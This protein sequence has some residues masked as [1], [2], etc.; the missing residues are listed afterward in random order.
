M[1]VA[2][3]FTVSCPL[4][5]ILL[6]ECDNLWI[7]VTAGRTQSVTIDYAMHRSRSHDAVV[8]IYDDAGSVIATHEH[9]GEFVEP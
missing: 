5:N 8:R 7:G 4:A 6:F 9:A 3:R 1:I 2:Q